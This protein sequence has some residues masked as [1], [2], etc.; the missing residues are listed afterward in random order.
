MKPQ[1]PNMQLAAKL[2][3]WRMKRGLLLKVVA[4]DLKIPKSTWQRWEEG[5]R[6]PNAQYLLVLAGYLMQ[7]VCW[8]LYECSADCDTC[9]RVGRQR[10]NNGRS[11]LPTGNK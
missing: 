2:K 8:L 1:Q 7:P 10:P 11:R 9:Q 4:A 5:Q 6:I 3:A